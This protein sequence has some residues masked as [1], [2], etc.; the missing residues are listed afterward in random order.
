MPVDAWAAAVPNASS[1]QS[2]TSAPLP[3]R[4]PSPSYS[5]VYSPTR[6]EYPEYDP[7]DSDVQSPPDLGNEPNLATT[8]AGPMARAVMGPLA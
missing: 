6:Y 7:T 4:N 1:A 5:P 3:S 2:L 8:Y